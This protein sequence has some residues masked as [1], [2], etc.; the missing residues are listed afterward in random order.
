MHLRP[1][2]PAVQR[3]SG[4]IEQDVYF[5]ILYVNRDP[6]VGIFPVDAWPFVKAIAKLVNHGVLGALGDKLAV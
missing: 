1:V 6:Q 4:T 2:A 5:G 3:G